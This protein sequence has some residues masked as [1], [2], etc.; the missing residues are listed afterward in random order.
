M[1]DFSISPEVAARIDKLERE[2][3]MLRRVSF[4]TTL[5][6]VA[7]TAIGAAAVGSGIVTSKTFTIVDSSGHARVK[8]DAQGLHVFDGKGRERLSAVVNSSNQPAFRLADPTGLVRLRAYITPGNDPSIKF[9]DSQNK[10]RFWLDL[11]SMDFYDSAGNDR[12]VVGMTQDN[13]APIIRFFTADNKNL[14]SIEGASAPFM[15]L[16]DSSGAKRAYIGIY[17]DGTSGA[18]FWDSAG[19]ATWSTP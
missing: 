12:L 15:R 7:V 1:S 16:Y 9:E 2:G 5:A 6:L 4:V 19:T 17:G 8:L 11:S 13:P 18:S 10:D 3:R 14:I